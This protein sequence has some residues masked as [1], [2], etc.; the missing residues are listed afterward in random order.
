MLLINVPKNIRKCS[1]ALSRITVD[2]DNII[3]SVMS[4]DCKF[5]IIPD[6]I[7]IVE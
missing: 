5:R 1:E 3:S 4:V 7:R 2:S 6:E